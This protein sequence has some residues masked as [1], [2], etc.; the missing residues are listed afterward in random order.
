M[1]TEGGT[2]AVIAALMANTGIAIT[3]SQSAEDIARGID[4]A[5]RLL[6]IAVPSAQYV[7]LEPDFDTS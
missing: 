3:K 5:E 7:F 2:K 6:R 1:S 4:E